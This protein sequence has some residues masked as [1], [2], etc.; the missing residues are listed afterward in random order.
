MQ[1]S[2][3]LTS[4][5][6]NIGVCALLFSL[7]SILRKQPSNASVY[8]GR[9]IATGRGRAPEDPFCIDRFVPSPSWLL[10]A[11]QTTEDEILAVGG[12]DA[13]VFLRIVVFS[14]RVFSVA[15]VVCMFV[16]LPMNYYG[17]EMQ[18]KQ[19][20]SEELEVFT[21]ANVK[22]GSTWIGAHCLALYVISFSA[23]MLLYFEYKSITKMR[24]AHITNSPAN[25]SHFTVLV[26]SIPWSPKESYG[27]MVKKFFTNYYASSYLSHQMVYR[28]GTVHKLMDDAELIC[29][30]LKSSVQ[31]TRNLK[32]VS[33][34]LCG[35]NA[36]SFRKLTQEGD[37]VNSINNN[38][39]SVKSKMHLTALESEC[40][41]AFVFFKTRYAADVAA[42]VLQSSNPMLWVT[43]LAPEPHDILW[44]NLSIPYRQL[45]IRKIA[46]LIAAIAFMFVFLIPVAFIQGM[47]QLE[48]LSQAFPFLK[49]ILEK[50][51]MSQ[52]VTGYLPSVILMTFLYAVPPTMMLFSVLEGPVSRSGRKKSA[53]LKVLFF[54]IWNVFFVN[55]LSGSVIRQLSIFSSVRD[56]PQQLAKAVPTQASFFMTYVLSSGWAGLACELMQLFPLTCNMLRK[57]VFRIEDEPTYV[58]FSFPYHTEVPRVLLFGLLGFTCSI[59]APLIVPLLLIYFFLAFLIYRNQ[60]LNVYFSKYESGGQFWPIAHNTTIFSLVLTQIIALGVFGMKQSPVSSGFTVPLIVLTLLFNEY[61]RQRFFPIFKKNAAQVLMEMDRQDEQ[62]GRLQ[63]IYNQLYTA[64]SRYP[65]TSPSIIIP[66]N[67]DGPESCA[68]PESLNQALIK[69]KGII[70][71]EKD[72]APMID[73]K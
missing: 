33:C 1:I 67:R 66:D 70:N 31:P 73:L 40:A 38:V 11:W 51:L 49:G 26:R 69:G 64:Y 72:Y 27:D 58:S 59:M 60:I 20:P 18:H 8:F 9:Q 48:S 47:T 45:W 43:E 62:S 61:C 30:R 29:Q 71:E 4:A 2:A 63:E 12:M 24:L 32:L 35:D 53:C 13:V 50:P 44:S 46:T 23:C 21:I 6:I 28:S 16:L 25:P 56:I 68:D 57:W 19:I 34:G 37:S 17:Q 36:N 10:E 15:A 65:M 7:Y 22:E 41:A 3:L 39:N 5:G 55:I 14:L 54:T 42:D 52:L